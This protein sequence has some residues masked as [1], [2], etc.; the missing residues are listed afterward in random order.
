MVKSLIICKEWRNWDTAEF[1]LETKWSPAD[2]LHLLTYASMFGLDLADH[3]NEGGQILF[4]EFCDWAIK[5]K[6]DLEN[7]Q[8]KK[9]KGKK[10]PQLVASTANKISGKSAS[11][12][13]PKL[14]VKSSAQDHN[15]EKHSD[16]RC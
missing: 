10:N 15:I 2:C 5:K 16:Y 9:E 7:I 8:A 1:E 11:R 12:N 14:R 6:S 4:I 3:R 13:L